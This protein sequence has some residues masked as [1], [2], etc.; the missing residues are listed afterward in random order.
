M[1]NASASSA[2]HDPHQWLEEVLGEAPLDW[3]RDRNAES[4]QALA[5]D[6]GF[7]GMQSR[8]RSILDSDDRIA[9]VGRRS[10]GGDTAGDYYNFWRDAEHPRGIWR[11]TT[12]EEYV[13]EDPAWETV[14]D[15][16]ALAEQEGE[17][18]VWEGSTWLLPSRERCLVSLS[19]GGADASIVREFD[20]VTKRFVPSGEGG[21][22]LG[23]AKSEVSWID[24]D[25]VYV[26]TDFGDEEPG[27]SMTDSGYPRVVKRWTRG[28]PLR[29]ARRVAVGRKED[30]SVS[31]YRTHTPGFE[32]DFLYEGLTFF[33]NRLSILRD[34]R[35][36]PIDKPD[37]A[38]AGTH[39]Q[40]LLLRLRDDWKVK[41]RT[42]RSGS[43]LITHLERYLGGEHDFHVLFEPTERRSL[44]GW[45]RTKSHLI[46]NV[47]DNV[48]SV[49]YVA[50]PP[51]SSEADS[52]VAWSIAELPGLPPFGSVWVSPVDVIDSDDY[53]LGVTGYLT[54]SSLWRGT[55]GGGS[56]KMI[57]SLPA[58]FDAKGLTV[59]QREAV[60]EDGTRVPYFMIMSSSLPRDGRQPT[61]L[62]GYGGFEISLTPNYSATMGA[63]WL[64]KGGVYVVANIRGGG[65][66]GPRWHQAALKQNRNKAYEDFA[67]VAR[68][69]IDAGITSPRHLGIQGGSNGGL[70]VGNMMVMYPEL[71]RAVVCRVPLL[72]MLRYH[73]LLAGASWVGEYGDPDI[74]QERGWLRRFSPYHNV[75]E[76]GRYPK[77]LL[78]TS[79]RDDRVHPGHARKMTARMQAQGHDVLYYENIEGGHGGAA[80]HEQRAYLEALAWTF[81]WKTLP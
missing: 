37:S 71:F 9:Y 73:K 22:V 40:W 24:R 35:W 78:T 11:R 3:V 58:L 38:S 5:Q 54:P 7:E 80:D 76:E 28:T 17:N 15:L 60:S 81:L 39:R 10:I 67:A 4:R 27:G 45:S 31:A 59:Y 75:S 19:R 69:L 53:W 12:W 44:A 36:H 48:R 25:T 55:A 49:V 66:F 46:L 14:L 74:P 61:L 16:D 68:D 50:T 23:E 42:Y 79:T 63:S 13:K 18:W 57:K 51:V 56:A 29:E 72:D 52:G 65:E 1:S 77:V 34:G 6:P 43:L 2:P 62:Y 21:F 33:T 64:E 41:G 8:I 47:L 30:I 70:L 32:N 20:P 26:A